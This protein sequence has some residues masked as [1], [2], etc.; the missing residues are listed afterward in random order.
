MTKQDR[1]SNAKNAKNNSKQR[2]SEKPPKM[3]SRG[4]TKCRLGLV[5]IM[6]D[7]NNILRI[8]PETGR[9]AAPHSSQTINLEYTRPDTFHAHNVNVQLQRPTWPDTFAP[10]ELEQRIAD[11]QEEGE[12]YR[13]SRRRRC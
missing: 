12:S 13:R 5:C 8:S 9:N 2:I 10:A 3:V 11:P 6:W 1:H 7:T 4:I